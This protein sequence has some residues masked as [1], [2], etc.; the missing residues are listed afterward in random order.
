MAI[1]QYE[2]P[3]AAVKWLLANGFAKKLAEQNQSEEPGCLPNPPSLDAEEKGADKQ[4]SDN[5]E[6]WQSVVITEFTGAASKL[7]IVIKGIGS[8]LIEDI[9]TLSKSEDFVWAKVESMLNDR[10]IELIR[11]WA[12][13]K[14]TDADAADTSLSTP[15]GDQSQAN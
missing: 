9:L 12:N 4:I 2:V 13:A 7:E 11:N 8:K 3:D 6:P 5:Q 1:Q 14:L 15:G 10:Q